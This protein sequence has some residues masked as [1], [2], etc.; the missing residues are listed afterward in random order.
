MRKLRL[1]GQI[2]SIQAKAGRRASSH[3]PRMLSSVGKEGLAMEQLWPKP[4]CTHTPSPS[5]RLH[6]RKQSGG[7]DRTGWGGP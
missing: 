4:Y 1:Y 3:R 2:H 5:W 7:P 6:R